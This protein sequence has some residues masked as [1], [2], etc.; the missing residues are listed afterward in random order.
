[1]NWAETADEV[2][3]GLAQRGKYMR[4]HCMSSTTGNVRQATQKHL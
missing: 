2:P 1:M 4:E 3:V